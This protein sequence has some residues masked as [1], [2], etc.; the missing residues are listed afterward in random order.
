M[1]LVIHRKQV[2]P[3]P[4][5]C[6]LPVYNLLINCWAYNGQARPVFS[7]IASQLEIQ[8]R[9]LPQTR[10]F[11]PG[12]RSVRNSLIPEIIPPCCLPES[13]KQLQHSSSST[14]S[15]QFQSSR[16]KNVSSN[17]DARSHIS[18]STESTTV[19]NSQF[20]ANP[21]ENSWKSSVRPHPAPPAS[22]AR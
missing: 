8:H 7:K 10:Q 13:I 2:L 9:N 3:C 21:Y 20:V 22:P 1:E 19:S 16:N 6:P 14:S 15:F 17:V 12:P 18:P 5:G 4:D 11:H